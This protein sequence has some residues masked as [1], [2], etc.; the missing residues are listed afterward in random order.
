MIQDKNGVCKIYTLHFW[1]ESR[2]SCYFVVSYTCH[3]NYELGSREPWENFEKQNL[4]KN[5]SRCVNIKKKQSLEGCGNYSY[6]VNF[7]NTLS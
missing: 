4:Y 2:L 3:K 6:Q 7:R 5:G 1:P